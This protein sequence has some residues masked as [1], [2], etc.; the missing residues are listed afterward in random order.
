MNQTIWNI[1]FLLAIILI[2][3]VIIAYYLY[4]K[5]KDINFDVDGNGTTDLGFTTQNDG[6]TVTLAHTLDNGGNMYP[7]SNKKYTNR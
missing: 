3:I 7:R 2:I 5:N 6:S 4:E 1:I